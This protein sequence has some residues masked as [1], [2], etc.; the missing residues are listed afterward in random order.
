MLVGKGNKRRAERTKWES[1]LV[2]NFHPFE[3]QLFLD[4]ALLI[5]SAV[6]I[7]CVCWVNS[8]KELM[9]GVE[10]KCN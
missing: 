6:P 1:L 8:T 7:Y 5:L 9:N 2:Y 3:T 10:N 4:T